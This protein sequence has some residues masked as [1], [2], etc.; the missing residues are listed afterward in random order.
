MVSGAHY[1]VFVNRMIETRSRFFFH[2][3]KPTIIGFPLEVILY[4][5]TIY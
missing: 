2:K 3:E 4:L 1:S 5:E